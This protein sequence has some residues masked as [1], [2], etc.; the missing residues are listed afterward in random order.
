MDSMGRENFDYHEH[1]FY[2]PEGKEMADAYSVVGTPTVV[3]NA[4]KKL[5][6]PDDGS[7]NS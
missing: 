7:G 4:E 3:I 5:K 2:S 6:N 1:D